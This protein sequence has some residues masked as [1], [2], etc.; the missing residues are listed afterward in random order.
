MTAP[1]KRPGGRPK[2][3]PK[4]AR[5]VR[6]IRLNE[7]RWSKLKTLGAAWLERAIDRAKV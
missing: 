5:R 7:A 1:A 6:A 4:D 3:A 2:T